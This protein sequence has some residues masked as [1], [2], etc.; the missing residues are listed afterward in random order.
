MHPQ[1]C[2]IAFP[3]AA[4]DFI[5][6][7]GMGQHLSHIL[8]KQAQQLILGGRQLYGGALQI[9]AA[10]SI[11]NQEA[12]VPEGGLSRSVFLSGQPP[13]GNP[14]PGQK[15][16]HGK[17]L[18]QVIVRARIQGGDFVPVLTAGT[19]DNNGHLGPGPDP[20]DDLHPI[21]IRQSQIQQHN[22]RLPGGSGGN[23][24][25]SVRSRKEAVIVGFECG[26]NQVPDGSVILHHQNQ[27]LIHGLPPPRMGL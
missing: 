7:I 4:P 2:H 9:G 24:G 17:G 5:G 23:G 21:H 13:L 16:R 27:W 14:Q 10:R 3:A 11:V 25:F 26:G 18:G 19:D 1:G 15:L 22:V 12:A 8:G 6:Q 20:A